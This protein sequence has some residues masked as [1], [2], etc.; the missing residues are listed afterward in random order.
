MI[1]NIEIIEDN[2]N[3]KLVIYFEKDIFEYSINSLFLILKEKEVH[4]QKYLKYLRNFYF[5]YPLERIEF[6]NIIKKINK[7]EYLTQDS[8]KIGLIEF[9]F[10]EITKSRKKE[11]K[12]HLKAQFYVIAPP[13]LYISIIASISG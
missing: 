2:I 6:L 10:Q 7:N 12:E 9:L 5:R 8:F 11:I 13:I 3:S 1:K 4:N